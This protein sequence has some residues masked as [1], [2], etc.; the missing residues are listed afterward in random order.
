MEPSHVSGRLDPRDVGQLQEAVG[1][2]AEAETPLLRFAGLE[3]GEG[4]AGDGIYENV[5]GM[6]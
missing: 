1:R 5:A 3:I 6:P 2:D 4:L